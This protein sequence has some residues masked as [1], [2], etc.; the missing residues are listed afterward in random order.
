MNRYSRLVKKAELFEVASTGS[1]TKTIFEKLAQDAG[2]SD[3]TLN[4]ALSGVNSE[5]QN[6]INSYGV[7]RSDMANIKTL[8]SGAIGPSQILLSMQK[9]GNFSL[10]NLQRA[11][12]ATRSL[13]AVGSSGFAELDDD[14]KSAWMSMVSPKLMNLMGLLDQE[15]KFLKST[16]SKMPEDKVL[17]V[18]DVEV[19]APAPA[20]EH[21]LKGADLFGLFS[22]LSQAVSSGQEPTEKDKELWKY[23]KSAFVN[24]VSQLQR[25]IELEQNKDNGGNPYSIM[26]WEQERDLIKNVMNKVQPPMIEV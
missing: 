17:N 2:V 12:G 26:E 20:A 16:T 5:I 18:P 7:K 9:S 14:Q 25:M 4:A 19:S 21:K 8:P 11:Y 13:A 10:D 6:W 22:R 1:S 24:R 23:N 3:N 15:I